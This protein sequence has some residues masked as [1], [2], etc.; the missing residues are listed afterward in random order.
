MNWLADKLTE[1]SARVWGVSV[2]ITSLWFLNNLFPGFLLAAL[3]SIAAL[4]GCMLAIL[5]IS[6]FCHLLWNALIH[7][8]W[9]IDL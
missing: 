5:L 4:L 8:Q 6:L 3:A 9:G 1:N 7:N 2:I